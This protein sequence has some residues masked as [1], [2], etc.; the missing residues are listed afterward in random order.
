WNI[1]MNYQ[2]HIPK[3]T[4]LAKVETPAGPMHWLIERA[5]MGQNF[6]GYLKNKLYRWRHHYEE[7]GSFNVNRLNIENPIV[8]LFCSTFKMAE[9]IHYELILDQLPYQ[10]LVCVEEDYLA[11]DDLSQAFYEPSGTTLKPVALPFLQSDA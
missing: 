4:G 1:G 9:R 8:V 5:Q 3:V 2:Q 10:V 7:A 11:K 6:I